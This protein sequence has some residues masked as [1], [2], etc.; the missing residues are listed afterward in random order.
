MKAD[1]KEALQGSGQRAA[2]RAYKIKAGAGRAHKQA[3]EAR[4]VAGRLPSGRAHQQATG[5]VAALAVLFSTSCFSRRAAQ[6]APV[7]KVGSIS[8][9]AAD[10]QKE[11]EAG[12]NGQ[13]VFPVEEGL[14]KKKAIE[15][16][17][18][19]SLLKIWAEREADNPAIASPQAKAESARAADPAPAGADAQHGGG[20]SV[21]PVQNP[22]AGAGLSQ[23]Q[24]TGTRPRTRRGR[25]RNTAA[26]EPK[27]MLRLLLRSARERLQLLSHRIRRRMQAQPPA[28]EREKPEPIV[29]NKLQESL[30]AAAGKE[31]LKESALRDFYKRNKKSF[32]RAE[33]R[34]LEHILVSKENQARILH[35]RL[36]RG[37]SFEETAERRSL[38]PRLIGWTERGVLNIFDKA[39]DTVKQGAFSPPLESRYGWHI[40]RAGDLIPAACLTFEEAKEKIAKHVREKQQS[41]LFKQWIQTELRLSPVFLNKELLNRLQ[42]SYKKRL[43]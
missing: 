23:K 14:I 12:L 41:A 34:F 10:L 6:T 9:T 7:L 19:K 20:A 40:F 38:A 31:P 3:G 8:W 15:E 13:P 21:K 25:T 28:A 30:Q 17:V 22:A 5:F 42:I 26:A 43:F 29:L 24:A 4:R 11:I 39:L 36:L 35:R 32:C 2:G 18:F 16:L 37:E 1:A 27:Q 33:R